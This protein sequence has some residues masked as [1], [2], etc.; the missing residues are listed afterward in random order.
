MEMHYVGCMEN[1][2][3]IW[4]AES[5]TWKSEDGIWKSQEPYGKNQGV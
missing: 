4:K 2:R 1:A 3:S 5:S